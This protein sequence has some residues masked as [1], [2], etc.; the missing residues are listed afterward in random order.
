[1]LKPFGLFVSFGSASG[2]ISA[3]ELGL[4]TQ[5]GS[6]YA[7]RPSLFDYIARRKDYEA[8]TQDLLKA[9]K[10]GDLKIQPPD[11]YP[12]SEARG[13]HAALEAR[14]SHRSLGAHPLIRAFFGFS[15]PRQP[16]WAFRAGDLS[17][18]RA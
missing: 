11:C 2:P 4:L 9:I 1:L 3:F 16:I 5:K 13:V 15:Q 17:I 8:M 7:T 12:L 10:R 6:L 18:G 14:R